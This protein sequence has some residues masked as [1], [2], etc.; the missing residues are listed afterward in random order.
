MIYRMHKDATPSKSRLEE[1]VLLHFLPVLL[2][3]LDA[4]VI[5]L[6]RVED[7]QQSTTYAAGI[8]EPES[9]PPDP[10]T[11]VRL[12]GLLAQ[13]KKDL[14]E[15]V[16]AYVGKVR[17]VDFDHMF[18]GYLQLTDDFLSKL[19][20]RISLPQAGDHFHAQEGDLFIRRWVRGCKKAMY[21]LG[22]IPERTLNL[23]GSLFARQKKTLRPW[24]HRVNLRNI[25]SFYFRE[26]LSSQMVQKMNDVHRMIHVTTQ[27]L[28]QRDESMNAWLSYFKGD[29]QALVMDIHSGQKLKDTIRVITNEKRHLQQELSGML[30]N[31]YGNF[32]NAV[33][34]AG[35]I[36]LP[37]FV[38]HKVRIRNRHRKLNRTFQRME[39]EWRITRRGLF[40]DWG[41]DNELY[42]LI[43]ASFEGYYRTLGE[44]G[45]KLEHEIDPLLQR[46]RDF[47]SSCSSRIEA[48]KNAADTLAGLRKEKK[49][50]QSDLSDKMLPEIY[51]Q[52][53]K[54]D[55]RAM[56]DQLIKTIKEHVDKVSPERAISRSAEYTRPFRSGDI[57]YVSPADLITFECLPRLMTV[58]EAAGD[59]MEAGIRSIGDAVIEAGEIAEFGLES[60][61]EFMDHDSQTESQGRIAREGIERTLERM[62]HVSYLYNSLIYLMEKDVYESFHNFADELEKFTDNSNIIEIRVRIVKGK[63]L[64]HLKHL[65]QKLALKIRQLKP[66]VIRSIRKR[67]QQV[68]FRLRRISRKYGLMVEKEIISA[69]LAGVLSETQKTVLKLPFVYQRLFKVRPLTDKRFFIGRKKELQSMLSAYAG[70]QKGRYIPTLIVG[71][72]GSGATS[73]INLFLE[74][75]DRNVPVVRLKVDET[76]YTRDD[77]LRFLNDRL[78]KNFYKL[79]EWIDHLASMDNTIIVLE[80]CQRLY[81]KKVNG[82]D[83]IHRMIDLIHKTGRNVLWIHTFTEYAFGYLDK[84]FNLSEHYRNIIRLGLF[85]DPDMIEVIDHRHKV[86]GFHT[87]YLPSASDQVHKKYRGA[88]PEEQQDFL[89]KAFFAD[90]TRIARGNI[91]IALTYWILSIRDVRENTLQIQSLK[92]L[93][94]S[95]LNGLSSVKLFALAALILHEMLCEEDFRKVLNVNSSDAERTLQS[96]YDD[97]ILLLENTYYMIN[98]I[99]YRQIT[100]MLKNK[101]LIH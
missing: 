93:D 26:L 44:M 74:E 73:L 4:H 96:L 18:P 57:H 86:S 85:S 78:Q 34:I 2:S 22:K 53:N 88:L 3:K 21:N 50:V 63:T 52:A 75:I 15:I 92:D 36:E 25:S 20:K 40:D 87:E 66:V 5:F 97:G 31:L 62:E 76:L 55:F 90:L 29:S 17:I 39:K 67:Y 94:L 68:T 14:N 10:Q 1:L 12:L 89:R 45:Q 37:N 79:E 61:L 48:L 69:D 95:F 32:E 70:W 65:R 51:E 16:E 28:W 9:M 41:I 71:E 27:A 11:K 7:L 38:F 83:V 56:L 33:H 100:E 77:L 58:L 84:I 59:R 43:F 49:L 24:Q 72:K 42:L 6:K 35:T 80:D 81:I 64:R 98:P 91:R 47:L 46:V 23:L 99:L 101:N 30:N 60:A 8:P 13:Y 19:P 82:F 54:L